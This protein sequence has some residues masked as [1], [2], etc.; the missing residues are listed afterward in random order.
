MILRAAMVWYGSNLILIFSVT[1]ACHYISCFLLFIV[2]LWV[3]VQSNRKQECRF[4]FWPNLSVALLCFAIQDS[5]Y[6][7]MYWSDVMCI[8]ST[9]TLVRWSCSWKNL[10]RT[11]YP[12]LEP[13]W[14]TCNLLEIIWTSTT[15]AVALLVRTG[16]IIFLYAIFL[17]L[18]VDRNMAIVFKLKPFR[19]FMD[20]SMIDIM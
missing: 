6:L 3:S 11:V 9:A 17:I 20:M 8:H 1:L 2:M 14:A 15:L 13:K 12:S 16:M 19:G 7:Y 10:H 5:T 4:I 18:C